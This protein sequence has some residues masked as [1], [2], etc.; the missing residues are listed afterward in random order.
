[1]TNFTVSRVGDINAGGSDALQLFLKKFS[2]EVL[3]T[4]DEK[5]VMLGRTMVRT[6]E[7]G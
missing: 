1:M 6:I 3:T 5:N 4:F 7:N 2:G